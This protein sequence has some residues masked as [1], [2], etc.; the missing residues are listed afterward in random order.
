MN[1]KHDYTIWYAIINFICF[2][3][4]YAVS[5]M[6]FFSFIYIV[7][8]RIIGAIILYFICSFIEK[9]LLMKYIN[10]IVMFFFPKEIRQKEKELINEIRKK[11]Y[12]KK[13]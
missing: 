7:I 5:I 3:I 4:I 12:M 6:L 9:K 10:Y 2:L 13:K 8:I 11:S 1:K